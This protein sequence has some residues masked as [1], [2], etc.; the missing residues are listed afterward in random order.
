[1]QEGVTYAKL[2]LQGRERFQR[3]REPLGIKSF[4]I[5]L[6]TLQPGQRGRIHRHASQEEVY[7]VL[8]G[9]L[10]LSIEG[11]ERDLAQGEIAR[12]APEVR[13]QLL[14]RGPERCVIL[15]LGGAG[16]H[17]GRD[18]TGFVSWEATEGAPPQE[19]PLPDDLPA[20]ERRP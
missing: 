14:N 18:G 12:V 4:G 11:T 10:S 6:L 8:Q 13:R 3:L 17:V 9:V 7:L 19:I 1:M 20:A 16:E 15:G 2:D 5:N